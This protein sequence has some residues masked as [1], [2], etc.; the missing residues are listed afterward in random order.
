MY[1]QEAEP[2][3]RS[4]SSLQLKLTASDA[5]SGDAFGSVS[6]SGDTAIVGAAGDDDGGSLSGSAYI[7]DFDDDNDGILDG[8]DN[9]PAIANPAQT[10]TDGDGLGDVCDVTEDAKLTALDAAFND[11]FGNSVSISGDTAIVG[12]FGDDDGGIVSGSAYVFTRS[13][14]IWTQQAKLT[15]S[16]AA[17]SDFFGASVSLSGDTAIVGA[18]LDDDGGDRSGSAYVFVKPAGGWVDS[19][20]TAKLTASDATAFDFFGSSVSILGDTII[21]GANGN[22]DAGSNSGSAYVF[23]KPAGGWADSTQTAKLTASDAAANDSFGDSVSILGDTAIVG[24]DQTLIDP[25]SAY[26]FVKPAGGWADSTQTAK[27]TASDAAADDKFGSSVSISGDTAIVGANS[28]DDGGV[29]SGSA[30]VFVKLAGGWADSTQTA[31][32]T[33]LDATAGDRFGNSVSISGN[34]AIVGAF[35]DGDKDFAQS[36][37]AYVFVKPAGG[38]TDSPHTAKLTA[39][40]AAAGDFFGASVSI[41]GD[42][43]IVGADEV[44]AGSGS[45]YVFDISSVIPPPTD[46]DNDG[47]FA[48]VDPDDNDPC[49]PNTNAAACLAITDADNDG[50]F[51]D[52]DPDDNDPCN[53]NTNA[54]ACLAITD[55]D[56]D[57]VLNFEDNCP[58]I[59]NPAQTD[60]D[61]DGLGDTCDLD[62]DNDGIADVVDLQPLVFSND[63]SDGTTTGSIVRADREWQISDVNDD[64]LTSINEGV[65]INVGPGIQN[66]QVQGTGICTLDSAPAG[67]TVDIIDPAGADFILSCSSITIQVLDGSAKLSTTINGQ[68]VSVVV[69]AGQGVTYDLDDGNLLVTNLNKTEPLIIKVNGQEVTIPPNNTITVTKPVFDVDIDIKP[70]SVPSSVSCKTTKGGV[71]VAIFGSDTFDVSTID[72]TT[73]QLNGVPVT[74]VHNKIHIED[75]NGDEFPDAVLHLDKAGVCEAT[76]DAD[77]YPLKK[78]RDATLTVSN[79][80][81]DFTGIGDIRIVK[82]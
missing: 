24:A 27:L 51:A 25:G 52:V 36:G 42:T 65:R 54:A 74:E 31:K 70:G 29:S 53:P 12:A 19:T 1:L 32:L 69:N 15:A 22:D 57:G 41:S 40:D 76:S 30:Y 71:P 82:R 63:F 18:H 35:G 49:N 45:A 6:I 48:D 73:L 78:S 7:F 11:R 67:S 20:Q 38:W 58:A 17:A 72:L 9:C 14:T 37:S 13:G 50:V 2:Y 81:G 3:G 43:A 26:V 66:A 59:A 60:T 64:P 80:Q 46:A 10:D 16:D 8:V 77:D 44:L 55:S 62:D 21:V 79:A 33:A 68:T 61:G 47:V 39:S 23:V 4:K 56:G 75:K 28:D 34:I 5:A